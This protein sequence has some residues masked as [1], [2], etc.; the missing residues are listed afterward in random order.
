[1]ADHLPVLN[2][3]EARVL[4][5]LIEKQIAT[6]DYYPLSLNALV[7]ACNQRTNRDPVVAYEETAVLRALDGLR[8]KRLAAH[9]AGAENRVAKFKHSLPDTLLLTPAET[10][11]LCGLLLRGPQTP[12][13][14]RSR[15]ERLFKFDTLTEV[16][17]VLTALAGHDPQP[18]ATRLPRLPG[19]KESR[20]AQLF[21]GTPDATTA[22]TPAAPPQAA[23]VDPPSDEI[24]EL[25]QQVDDL[26]RELEVLKSRFTEFRSQFD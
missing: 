7:N 15:S 13:E 2:A 8:E 16:E 18:L 6:P 1:M 4:G 20:W 23:P 24:A 10:V 26:R 11:L 5:S 14:L 25:R 22:A 12:G 9:F 3:A 17:E 19:T 21:T